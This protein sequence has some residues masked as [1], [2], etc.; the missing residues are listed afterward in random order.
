M[1]D[2]LCALVCVLGL[3]VHIHFHNF[4]SLSKLRLTICMPT[5]G[6]TLHLYVR[7]HSVSMGVCVHV[8]ISVLQENQPKYRKIPMVKPSL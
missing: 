4:L 3:C 6:P 1:A 5:V 8:S 2:I 7:A